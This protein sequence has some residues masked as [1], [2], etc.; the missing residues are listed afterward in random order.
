MILEMLPRDIG[1]WLLI[2]LFFPLIIAQE[3]S[4]VVTE[5]DSTPAPAPSPVVRLE[6]DEVEKITDFNPSTTTTAPKT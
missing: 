6:E 4:V 5:T 2:A 1:R 3:S